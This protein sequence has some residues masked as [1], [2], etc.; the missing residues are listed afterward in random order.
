MKKPT[1]K[2]ANKRNAIIVLYN[3]PVFK[4][5]LLDTDEKI[6]EVK[7]EGPNCSIKPLSMD[8]KLIP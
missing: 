5:T 1:K 7:P 4:F 3:T 8:K 6:V 2:K